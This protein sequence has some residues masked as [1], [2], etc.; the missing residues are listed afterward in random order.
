MPMFSPKLL[1]PQVDPT[2]WQLINVK[3][4]TVRNV[5][6]RSVLSRGEFYPLTANCNQTEKWYVLMDFGDSIDM[7]DQGWLYSWVFSS[8][9]WKSKHGFV[10]RRI[11]VRR[12]EQMQGCSAFSS[13]SSAEGS[14]SLSLP[15]SQTNIDP[16]KRYLLSAREQLIMGLMR[17]SLDRHRF[18][19]LDSSLKNGAI[20]K[21]A[22]E[23]SVFVDK[24]SR[25][26]EFKTSKER[27][28]HIWLPTVLEF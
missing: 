20:D 7:D 27:F 26:F 3:E 28:L 14:G 5:G 24:I 21:A 13:I 10:R 15:E 1:I 18:E 6:E 12:P 2:H 16:V 17:Q 23:D 8:A 4:S 22:L 25:C 11:W 19:L 9:R